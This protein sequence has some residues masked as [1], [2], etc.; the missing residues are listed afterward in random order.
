MRI[1]DEWLDAVFFLGI[2]TTEGGVATVGYGGT[3]FVL[4]A[5][6]EFSSTLRRLYLV[7]AAHNIEAARAVGNLSIRVN[8]RAGGSIVVE[9]DPFGPWAFHDDPTVDIAMAAPSVLSEVDLHFAI[10]QE[11]ILTAH[12]VE[13]LDFGIGS[14]LVAIGLFGSREGE[15]KNIPV[16]RTGIVAAMPG[17]PIDDDT[18]HGPYRAYL[19]EL[20]SMGGLSGSPVF[21]HPT[22]G[23][24]FPRVSF[25]L[26][27][28]I[29]SHWDEKP[30]NAP[31]DLSRREWINRGIA[32]VTPAT[33]ILEVLESKPMRDERRQ[34]AQRAKKV[35]AAVMDSALA[36]SAM[37]KEQFERALR[38]VSRRKPSPPAEETSGT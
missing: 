25:Y 29:R 3:G 22:R 18:G 24:E 35:R 31:A 8:T 9:A 32:T 21:F 5:P 28:I 23:T 34:D 36:E 20:L 12:D 1:P 38:K 37:T 30:P 33:G 27:G 13:V 11:Q 7:T 17:E 19:A 15:A 4:S 6:N 2:T 16:I 14:E 26:V 10:A